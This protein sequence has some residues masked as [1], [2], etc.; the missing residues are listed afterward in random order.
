MAFPGRQ[1]GRS[2]VADDREELGL[3][4]LVGQLGQRVGGVA[5]PARLDLQRTCLQPGHV[6]DSGGHHRQAIERRSDRPTSLLLPRHVGDH[7]DHDVEIEGMAHVH[8]S[9]EV[10]HV[11]GIERPPEQPNPVSG[12]FGI[13]QRHGAGFY[14][15][16]ERPRLDMAGTLESPPVRP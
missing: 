3:G 9:H 10:S 15:S 12:R 2:V 6:G 1:A 4:L 8:R 5:R 16:P 13:P 14:W 7:Q 11:R